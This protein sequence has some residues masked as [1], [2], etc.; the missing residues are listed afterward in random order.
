MSWEQWAVPAAA[1]AFNGGI[2]WATVRA[3][4]NNFAAFRKE[5]RDDIDSL[6][7]Q[8]TAMASTD[9]L[10]AERIAATSAK[11]ETLERRAH[12]DSSVRD[13]R[14]IELVREVER[15]KYRGAS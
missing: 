2:L 5:V 14:H 6:S 15:L 7:R 8:V 11:L 1:L 10:M 4:G 12:E 3:L 13:D 9:P